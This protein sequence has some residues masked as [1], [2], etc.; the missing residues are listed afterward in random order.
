MRVCLVQTSPFLT[1]RSWNYLEHLGLGF[2]EAALTAEGFG[3]DV[4]DATL[5]WE[6]V[7]EVLRRIRESREPYGLIGFSVNRSNLSSTMEAVDLL[8]AAGYAGHVALGGDFPTFH[9]QRL[10]PHFR[11]VDSIVLGHGELTLSRLCAA[12]R[13]HASWEGV[14]GLAFARSERD[15]VSSPCLENEDY[16]QRIASP[17]HRPRYG[18]ARIIT[19]RGCA[20][21]CSFC[22]VNSFDRWTLR[23]HY[24][25]RSLEAVLEEI[26]RLV[27]DH[28]VE[29]LW[30]SDMDFVGRDQ[31]FINQFLD[32]VIR[33]SYRL[34]LEGDCRVDSLSEPL[35][36]KLARAGF[37]C[38]FMGVESF[39]K[40]QTDHYGKFP[41]SY[42]Q[43]AEVLQTVKLLSRHGIAARYGFIMFDKD[44][45][46]EEVVHNHRIVCST[47]G[48]GALDG[49]ANKLVVLPG[50]P[51]ESQYLEDTEHC[52]RAEITEQNKLQAHLYY[53][54]YS[55][56]DPRVRFVYAEFL[57]YRN[58]YH[59]IQ[60]L[61]DARLRDGGVAYN[62]HSW[63]LW[64]LRD[65]YSLIYGR[66][67]QT[68]EDQGEAA[69]LA[70]ADREACSGVLV[71]SC[72]RHS[73]SADAVRAQIAEERL[74]PG[75]P[76]P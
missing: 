8:R 65:Q 43:D 31:T 12:L 56:R 44:T 57:H 2:I 9:F 53:T 30:L 24:A 49:L 15:I 40:R 67:L 52:R 70:D 66:I 25:R 33:R 61:F 23:S 74:H 51:I 37:S 55:F 14:P 4:V 1:H 69:R 73:L 3:V 42:H 58:I 45:T 41:H 62:D 29:H 76:Y 39:V 7:E 59:R 46:L 19:S 16:I 28:G 13:D 64:R 6:S 32:A 26:D 48:Y 72:A 71:D 10:L 47:V 68:A 5:N 38:L 60:A 50:T 36:R 27:K 20:W 63:A 21:R 17:V 75:P 18:V 54:Q 34:T 35:I 11:G 22:S